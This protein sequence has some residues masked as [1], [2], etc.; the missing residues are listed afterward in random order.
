MLSKSPTVQDMFQPIHAK[1]IALQYIVHGR[2]SFV[3]ISFIKLG[4]S[5]EEGSTYMFTSVYQSVTNNP[6][7]HMLYYLYL[8]CSVLL[9][10]APAWRSTLTTLEW[11]S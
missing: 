4:R 1:N 11:P 10:V 2:V 6:T 7:L 3:Y 9:M 8:T 5:E